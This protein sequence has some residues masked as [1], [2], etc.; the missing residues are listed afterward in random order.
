MAFDPTI[1]RL[2]GNTF[3]KYQRKFLQ[4]NLLRKAIRLLI[5]PTLIR[6][7]SASNQMKEEEKR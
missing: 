5:S 4:P 2:S 3:S 6:S 1:I 7:R